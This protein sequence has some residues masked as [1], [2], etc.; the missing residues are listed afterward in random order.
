MDYGLYTFTFTMSYPSTEKDIIIYNIWKPT[1]I[2]FENIQKYKIEKLQYYLQDHQVPQ[3]QQAHNYQQPY[4]TKKTESL[5]K[6]SKV[7]PNN[8]VPLQEYGAININKT[9]CKF[10]I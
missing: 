4:K 7:L 10:L 1:P 3:S 8:S 6:S 5:S 2:D 9:F